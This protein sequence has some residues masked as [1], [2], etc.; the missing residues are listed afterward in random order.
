[1]SSSNLVGWIFIN[2]I[3]AVTSLILSVIGIT[4]EVSSSSNTVP[5]NV[6]SA[7]SSSETYSPDS[8]AVWGSKPLTLQSSGTSI[9]IDTG[10]VETPAVLL[11]QS[12][13]LKPPNASPSFTMVFPNNNPSALTDQALCVAGVSGNILQTKWRTIPVGPEAD[14]GNIVYVKT[15]IA[16]PPGSF[17]KL[18]DAIAY[19]VTQSPAADNPWQIQMLPGVYTET[20]P[21]IVPSFVS[22]IGSFMDTVVFRGVTDNYALT[23]LDQ[24]QISQITIDGGSIAGYPSVYANSAPRGIQLSNVKFLN[25]NGCV[26]VA[27]LTTNDT[28]VSLTNCIIYDP[29]TF[30]ITVDGSSGS[31]NAIVYSNATYYYISDSNNVSP[32]VDV[33]S[34]GSYFYSADDL[35]ER[36]LPLGAPHGTFLRVSNSGAASLSGMILKNFDT[37]IEINTGGNPVVSLNDVRFINCTITVVDYALTTTSIPTLNTGIQFWSING[38]PSTLDFYEVFAFTTSWTGPVTLT[39]TSITIIRLGYIVTMSFVG[40]TANGSSSSTTLLAST[41]MPI[42]FRPVNNTQFIPFHIQDNNTF[43]N[44]VISVNTSGILTVYGTVNHGP[45]TSNAGT[46]GYASQAITFT[47]A[48]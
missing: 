15:P 18:S 33:V 25:C 34:E 5:P 24:S 4:R 23:L 1:M 37:G 44:T 21:I 39:N 36:E 14:Q 2:C 12:L 16:I 48:P 17:N 41:A 32:C 6:L 22:I 7:A 38:V 43:S 30:G 28:I 8:V 11:D 35:A 42:R 20:E 45:F 31:G 3:V 40:A 10:Y 46:T 26:G 29:I 19:V 47:C 13:L 27:T 9:N